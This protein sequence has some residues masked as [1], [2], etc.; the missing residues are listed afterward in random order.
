MESLKM[1]KFDMETPNKKR[2]FIEVS[3]SP[4]G[5]SGFDASALRDVL[6]DLLDQKLGEHLK[7]MK[8]DLA[9]FRRKTDLKQ[10]E[11]SQVIAS[12]KVELD[13][14]KTENSMLKQQ[15]LKLERFQRKNNLKIVG[16]KENKGE[17]IEIA[18][19]SMFNEFLQRSHQFD[20]KTLERVHRLGAFQRDRKRDV[21]AR[22]ANFKDKLTVLEMKDRLKERYGILLFDDLPL[23]IQ[24]SRQ[25]LHPVFNALRFVKENSQGN[26]PVK[27]VKLKD[28]SL[29]L[30]GKTYGLD[31][32][33]DLPPDLST[34]KLFTV[35]KKDITAFFR[36]YSPLSN[37]Y[38]CK[39]E[40]NGESFSSMEKYIMMEKAQIFGDVHTLDQM[41]NEHDPV[42]LKR[43]GKTVKNFDVRI[44]NEAIDS[45]LARGLHAKFTQNDGLCAFLRNT[46]NTEL[47]EAN[48]NDKK[49]A[50]GLSL[51]SKDIWDPSRWKG[52]NKLGTALMR[53]RDALN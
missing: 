38:R 7:S 33:D 39:F 48:P 34:D 53:V 16:L 35:N 27:S 43:L 15:L 5:K 44:W 40:V 24:K 23:E 37:H 41:R 51:F 52:E 9:Q 4:E 49:F 21:V 3:V 10:V 47:V 13:E 6:G 2:P 8:D 46:G 26:G 30:N 50:V 14:V 31:N 22:F 11:T 28:G 12:L 45:I 36:C 1:D 20:E 19:I 18:V 42:T 17:N 32:L 29:V 25:K